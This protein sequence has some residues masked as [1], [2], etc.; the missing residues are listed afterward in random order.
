MEVDNIY[1]LENKRQKIP[2]GQS[3]MDNPEKLGT[4]GTQDEGKN[5]I[6]YVPDTTTS[7]QDMSPLTNNWR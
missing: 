1:E 6:Q 2:K 4:Q 5:T 3:E 7:K